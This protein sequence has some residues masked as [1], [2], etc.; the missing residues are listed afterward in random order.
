MT[1]KP[2]VDIFINNSLLIY[3][4]K[5]T[6]CSIHMSRLKQKTIAYRNNRVPILNSLTRV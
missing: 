1:M 2:N 6:F 3:T 4:L 5:Y